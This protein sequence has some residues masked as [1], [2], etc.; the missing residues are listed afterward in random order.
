MSQ[1]FFFNPAKMFFKYQDY[2]KNPNKNSFAH[3]TMQSKLYTQVLSEQSTM[4]EL[5]QPTENWGDLTNDGKNLRYLS[6]KLIFKAKM[7]TLVE[8]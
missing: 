8:K 1:G 6:K 3:A 7:G 2:F 4:D 5:I